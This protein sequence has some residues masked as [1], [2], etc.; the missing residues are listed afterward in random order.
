M[1]WHWGGPRSLRGH[2]MTLEKKHLYK[3]RTESGQNNRHGLAVTL[4]TDRGTTWC[5]RP[6]PDA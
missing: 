1:W 2:V 3:R 6:D 5:R 4:L